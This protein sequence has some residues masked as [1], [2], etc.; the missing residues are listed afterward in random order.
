M[1]N[2]S[3]VNNNG[4]YPELPQGLIVMFG[5]KRDAIA[6]MD[7]DGKADRDTPANVQGEWFP[8]STDFDSVMAWHGK[9][10]RQGYRE[11]VLVQWKRNK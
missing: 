5:Y 3:L 10:R 1:K 2:F 11:Y 9:R 8:L 7:Y 4:S 6:Y